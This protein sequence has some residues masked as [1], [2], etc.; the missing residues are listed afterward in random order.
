MYTFELN[1]AKNDATLASGKVMAKSPIVEI[2]SAMVDGKDLSKYGKKADKAAEY[3]K[4]L[5]KRANA[6]DNTAIS[7]LNEIR[8]FAVQ[9]R[10]LEEIRLL[11][12]FGSY[13]QL[14]WGD[15]AYLVRSE[16]ENLN[17]QR[18]AEGQDVSTAFIRRNKTPLAPVTVSSGFKANYRELELGDMTTENTLMSQIQTDIRNKAALYVVNTVY[19]AVANATGVKYFYEAAGLAKTGIDEL[20]MKIR[21]YGKPTITADYAILAQFMPWIGYAGTIGS[22]TVANV[23]QRLLDE[24]ADTGLVGSYNGA[25]L[26]EM[27]NQYNFTELNKAG[28]NYATLLP[29]G[30]GFVTP[31]APVNGSAPVQTFSIGGLTSMSGNNVATGEVYTR[32]DLS[33]AAGVADPSA[34]AIVHD[35]NLD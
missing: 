19:N 26:Q 10:L 5:G 7:E 4:E 30:I 33:I 32:Y 11:G 20:L 1:N 6:G 12:V 23:S 25:I 34:I 15:T 17:A 18:Q 35:T 29:A 28:D 31:A 2:F 14:A 22:T 21:R 8:K 27:P 16:I 13:Q 24:I 9:P 3:I